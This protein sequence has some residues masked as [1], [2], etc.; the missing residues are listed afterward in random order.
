MGILAHWLLL[1]FFDSHYWLFHEM[2]LMQIIYA[3]I[4][5]GAVGSVSSYLLDLTIKVLEART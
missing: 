3:S 4:I 1:S 5:S 2:E